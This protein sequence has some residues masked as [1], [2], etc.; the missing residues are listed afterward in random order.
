MF[1]PFIINFNQT[2]ARPSPISYRAP[3]SAPTQ[4][5]RQ[6]V[7][8]TTRPSV[9]SVSCRKLAVSV[10]QIKTNVSIFSSKLT[11]SDESRKGT[12]RKIHAAGRSCR[13]RHLPNPGRPSSCNSR[14]THGRNRRRQ[15]AVRRNSS[16]NRRRRDIRV[17]HF[18][19]LNDTIRLKVYFITLAVNGATLVRAYIYNAPFRTIERICQSFVGQRTEF[20]IGYNLIGKLHY[21]PVAHP[22]PSAVHLRTVKATAVK[23]A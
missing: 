18:N 6:S 21:G 11:N 20:L 14:P 1:N 19:Y 13:T 12:D 23:P 2:P 10:T 16:R 22:E 3:P 9:P 7:P 17:P 5:E 15:I 8:D 4:I